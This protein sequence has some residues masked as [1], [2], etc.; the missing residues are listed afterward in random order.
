M[1]VLSMEDTPWDDG[2]HHSILF[3]ENDTIES[4]QQ[5]STLSTVF[6]ISSVPEST[7]DVLYGGNLS[8]ISNTFP[9]DISIKPRVV[10]NVHIGASCSID[11]VHTYKPLFQEFCEVFSWSYEEI[12]GIDVD[13]VVHEI[14]TYPNVK[15]IRQRLRPLH[16]CK[17]AAIKFEV[18]KILKADF[19]YPM[20]L[21]DWVSNLVTMNNKQGTIRVCVDYRDV[22]KACPKDNYPSH[23]IEQIIDDC[24]G[25]EIFSLMDGFSGYNQ[26]N[27]LLAEQHK[28]AF[29]C[30]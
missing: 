2:H 30:P 24:A 5:I 10:E 19:V 7:Q 26:I 6:V 17:A 16:P 4:Y 29:I 8:N 15:P 22:N 27:I 23:F 14:K 12:L 21:N 25:R 13:I 1:S 20:A 9:L 18:E 3:L 28:T 11:D